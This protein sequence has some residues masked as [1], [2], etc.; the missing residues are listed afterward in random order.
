MEQVIQR[1]RVLGYEIGEA[2]RDGVEQA[3]EFAREE[4]LRLANLEELPTELEGLLCERAA[5]RYLLMRGVH[6]VKLGD[7][8]L[9]LRDTPPDVARY[10]KV[11]W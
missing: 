11:V 9:E 2:E 5:E 3:I 4:L 7:L 10:R 8:T 6:R 1:L